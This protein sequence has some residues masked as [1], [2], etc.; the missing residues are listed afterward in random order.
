M[1][2]NAMG[3]AM[4]WNGKESRKGKEREGGCGQR[5]SD[6]SNAKVHYRQGGSWEG[7]ERMAGEGRGCRSLGRYV[8]LLGPCLARSP[9]IM[10]GLVWQS[11]AGSGSIECPW[12]HQL[13]PAYP[14][15]LHPLGDDDQPFPPMVK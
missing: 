2:H 13:L 3:N 8:G 9:F 1:A 11:A 12:P 7:R 4:R 15:P 6:S 14:P 10:T 5:Q